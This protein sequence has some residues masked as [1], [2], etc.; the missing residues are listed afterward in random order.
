MLE[1]LDGQWTIGKVPVLVLTKKKSSSVPNEVYGRFFF[2]ITKYNVDTQNTST[3]TVM[4]A[5]TQ[6]IPAI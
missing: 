1:E 3:L 6:T 4:N 5:R 2:L